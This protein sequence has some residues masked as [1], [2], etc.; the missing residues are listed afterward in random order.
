MACEYCLCYGGYHNHGCPNEPPAYYKCVDC[1]KI[2]HED[3]VN[4]DELNCTYVCPHCGGDAKYYEPK[5]DR[6]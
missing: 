2:I 3:D 6:D 5:V 1:Y 4:E